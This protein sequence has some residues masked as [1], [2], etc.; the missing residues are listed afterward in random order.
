MEIAWSSGL[1]VGVFAE[2]AGFLIKTA[3]NPIFQ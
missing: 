3:D 1:P 2:T